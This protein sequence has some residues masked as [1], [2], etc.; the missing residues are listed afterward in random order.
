LICWTLWVYSQ[1]KIYKTPMD[2][3]FCINYT[4]NLKK[5]AIIVFNFQFIE[6]YHDILL[7]FFTIFKCYITLHFETNK[8]YIYI[9]IF[10][11]LVLWL[12][13]LLDCISTFTLYLFCKIADLIRKYFLLI[14][15][16]ISFKRKII[17][18]CVIRVLVL[19][20]IQL[21]LKL[22]SCLDFSLRSWLLL[23]MYSVPK[24]IGTW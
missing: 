2:F 1:T 3:K 21:I 17:N 24:K 12:Q 16:I 15:G 4:L 6:M 23:L 14:P 5:N 18:R 8:L 11:K 13:A 20:S 7:K 19:K 9:Y 10:T 22:T